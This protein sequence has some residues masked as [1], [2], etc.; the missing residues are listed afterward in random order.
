MIHAM[1]AF[2]KRPGCACE[3]VFVF[4]PR[5]GVHLLLPTSGLGLFSLHSEL[6]RPFPAIK[7]TGRILTTQTD[8]PA[9]SRQARGFVLW[10]ED[11]EGLREEMKQKAKGYRVEDHPEKLHQGRQRS[12][13]PENP[14]P[15]RPQPTLQL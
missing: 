13:R 8:C 9:E 2:L 15:K 6:R 10:I 3:Q 11:E 12:P 1:R 5:I 7:Y 14:H 4:R